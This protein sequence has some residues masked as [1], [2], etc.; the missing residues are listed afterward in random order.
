[1]WYNKYTENNR[2]KVENPLAQYTKI[3]NQKRF[4][5]DMLSHSSNCNNALEN[6]SGVYQ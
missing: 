4:G 2:R 3:Q 1:M 6:A 5:Y